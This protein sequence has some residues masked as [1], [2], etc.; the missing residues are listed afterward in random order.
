MTRFLPF[1]IAVLIAVCLFNVNLNVTRWYV[2]INEKRH[3]YGQTRGREVN[4][5][6]EEEIF[7][8]EFDNKW[9]PLALAG[10][11]DDDIWAREAQQEF[12]KHDE[13]WYKRSY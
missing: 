6:E 1:V 8:K 11:N 3:F 7:A 2:P 9:Q 12:Y 4:G 10:F 13:A 5:P